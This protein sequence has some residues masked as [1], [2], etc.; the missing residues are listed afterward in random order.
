MTEEEANQIFQRC[1]KQTVT[2]M[3]TEHRVLAT[4]MYWEA[5]GNAPAIAVLQTIFEKV[6]GGLGNVKKPSKLDGA[7]L[8]Y[9]GGSLAKGALLNSKRMKYFQVKNYG[10]ID[11]RFGS[12]GQA[13]TA[14]IQAGFRRKFDMLNAGI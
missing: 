11:K 6:I 5:V 8:V 1:F 12:I 10:T 2:P 7:V 9:K 13:V 4:K 3:T 14:G